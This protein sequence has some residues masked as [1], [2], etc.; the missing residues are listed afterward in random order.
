MDTLLSLTRHCRVSDRCLTEGD[1]TVIAWHLAMG[2]RFEPV[3]LKEEKGQ[4]QKQSVLKAAAAEDD[5]LDSGF[6]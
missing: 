2:E 6:L 1:A 5:P 4:F 3:S